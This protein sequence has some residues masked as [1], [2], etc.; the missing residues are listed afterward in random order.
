MPILELFSTR[1]RKRRGEVPEVYTFDNLPDPLRVQIVHI[2]REGFGPTI[3]E[4]YGI[5]CPVQNAFREMHQMLAKEFGVFNLTDKQSDDA[6]TVVG[7]YFLRCTDVERALDI[8]ELTFGCLLLA[9]ERGKF[10]HR[11][12]VSPEEAVDELNLRFTQ[13]SVGYSFDSNAS[14]IIRIDSEFLHSEAVKPALLLLRQKRF[15]AA[16]DE[17]AK[18]HQHYREQR[19]PE[20]VA[21]CLKAFESTLKV[22]C[23]TRRWQFATTDTAKTLIKLCFDHHLIPSYLESEFGAL[24]SLLECGLPTIRNKTSGHGQGIIM[25]TVPPHLASFA[26]HLTA[27]NIIFLTECERQLG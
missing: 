25:T 6:F 2:W 23:S 14:K 3:Q 26:L 18:A 24:R 7:H 4:G 21:D 20:C 9:A 27:A 17:F 16:N 15:H 22:I 11:S 12:Q 13:H 8:I 10:S 19:Y 1:Q 5:E